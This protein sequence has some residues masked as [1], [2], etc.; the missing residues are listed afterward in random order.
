VWWTGACQQLLRARVLY[1]QQAHRL[2]T[3]AGCRSTY[4]ASVLQFTTTPF[5]KLETYAPCMLL[6]SSDSVLYISN[7][8][9]PCTLLKEAI[10]VRQPC[11]ARVGLVL[12]P[13]AYST[14]TV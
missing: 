3:R 9:F 2:E 10:Q 11:C 13:L 4:Q 14:V 7:Y 1:M 8:K 6:W 5:S 12:L